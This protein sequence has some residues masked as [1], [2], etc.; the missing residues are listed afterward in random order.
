MGFLGFG[1]KK[2]STDQPAVQSSATPEMPSFNTDL[3]SIDGGNM[4]NMPDIANLSNLPNMPPMPSIPSDMPGLP[5]MPSLNS[6]SMNSIPNN[7]ASNDDQSMSVNLPTLD[8]SMPPSDDEQAAMQVQQMNQMGQSQPAGS[9]DSTTSMPAAQQLDS[10]A[11]DVEDL[12]KLFISDDWKEPDFNNFEPYTEDKIEE[13]KP[14]DFSGTELPRFEDSQIS[15]PA[16]PTLRTETSS[17]PVE[18]FI[19]GRAYS[20]VFVE[21]DEMSSSLATLNSKSTS[22]EDIIKREDELLLAAK[23]QMEYLYKKI[24]IIDKKIFAQ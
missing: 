4:Q 16:A 20:R 13:P 6:P 12:N 3:P 9:I 11:I 7:T 1:K 5:D 14:E 22:Y 21:L 15:A 23:G 18:L 19:R 24:S 8:F 17:R 2:E 10:G